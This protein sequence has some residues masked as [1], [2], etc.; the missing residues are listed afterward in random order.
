MKKR[1][2]RATRTIRTGAERARMRGRLVLV[3]VGSFARERR[4]LA[5]PGGG[6]GT[7]LLIVDVGDQEGSV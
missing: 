1:A 3:W 4:A 2:A 6:S 5:S 7:V